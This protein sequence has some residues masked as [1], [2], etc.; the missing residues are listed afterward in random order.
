MNDK[1]DEKPGIPRTILLA[2]AAVAVLFSCLI[3]IGSGAAI[4]TYGF[5]KKDPGNGII[6]AD[7]AKAAAERM[8]L[9]NEAKKAALK[10]MEDAEL[11]GD[12]VAIRAAQ[13]MIDAAWEKDWQP[14]KK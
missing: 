5:G 2:I 10:A 3:C 13:A 14:R 9:Q 1:P 7:D 11:K 8:M 6:K 4:M 12:P